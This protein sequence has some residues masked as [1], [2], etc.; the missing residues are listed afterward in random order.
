MPNFLDELIRRNSG[1]A[2]AFVQGAF[3]GT[4]PYTGG[5]L[6]GLASYRDNFNRPRV[7]ATTGASLPLGG[8]EQLGPP[9]SALG[10][11]PLLNT[12]D[13][14][15]IRL[16][17]GFSPLGGAGGDVEVAPGVT[18]LGARPV[19]TP[20]A[21][22]TINPNDIK[23]LIANVGDPRGGFSEVRL[24][25]GTLVKGIT[26]DQLA[27]KTGG[28]A[29]VG[30]GEAGNF[31]D[32]FG[33]PQFQYLAGK[34]AQAIVPDPT[35]GV[36]L[37]GGVGADLGT[38]RAY[39]EYAQRLGAGESPASLNQDANF[40]ILSPELKSNAFKDVLAGDR[41]EVS[42]RYTEQL[43]NQSRAIE[44]ATPTVQQRFDHDT[45]IAM[46]HNKT[47]MNQWQVWGFGQMRNKETGEIK[48]VPTAPRSTGGDPAVQDRQWYKQ[49]Y[50]EALRSPEVMQYAKPNFIVGPD[51]VPVLQWLDA[52]KGQEALQRVFTARLKA[53]AGGG[54]VPPG[55]VDL[56][57]D[58]TNKPKVEF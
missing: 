8:G 22:A 46:I 32:F 55:F 5:L 41:A 37:A 27:P 30:A 36:N 40:S 29:P 45:L 39:A 38:N 3:G 50:S 52:V 2:G 31:L 23:S 7:D 21:P 24:P 44:G 28:E 42:N 1:G 17:S 35:H 13:P 48:Q 14:G 20:D 34:L 16:E 19:P 53:F 49:A 43:I 6:G 10:P 12:T 57:G 4:P 26:P 33:S 15:S 51:G 9:T 11:A 47:N 25:D 56:V 58:Q 18:A 54:Q